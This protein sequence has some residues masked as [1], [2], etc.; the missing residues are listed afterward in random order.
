MTHITLTKQEFEALK[1]EISL[2][3]L[4]DN[5]CYCLGVREALAILAKHE[6]GGD[7]NN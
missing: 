6:G 4:S 7:G 5:E 2:L 1:R 3:L